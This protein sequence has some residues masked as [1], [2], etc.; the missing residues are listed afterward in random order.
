MEKQL[1][2]PDDKKNFLRILFLIFN[3]T[4]L[5]REGLPA[6]AFADEELKVTNRAVNIDELKLLLVE[7]VQSQAGLESVDVVGLT[8]RISQLEINL[9][10]SRYPIPFVGSVECQLYASN[11]EVSASQTLKVLAVNSEEIAFLFLTFQRH[12]VH[13]ICATNMPSNRPSFLVKDR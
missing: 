6:L 13:S 8:L 4:T 3:F 11:V 9:Q 1:T 12:Q 2:N 10:S 7:F 5:L